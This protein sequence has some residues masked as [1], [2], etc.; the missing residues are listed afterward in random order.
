MGY[1]CKHPLA[2]NNASAERDLWK[3]RDQPI[4]DANGSGS[5]HRTD[6]GLVVD[7][8][9][10]LDDDGLRIREFPFSLFFD[11]Q[12]F[13]DSPSKSNAPSARSGIDGPSAVSGRNIAS[14]LEI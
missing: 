1:P 14:A 3:K 4:V 8:R 6:Q 12:Q 7:Y 5:V 11:F 9:F 13:W 2:S 10:S